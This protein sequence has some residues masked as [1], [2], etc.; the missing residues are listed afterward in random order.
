MDSPTNP[1]F[2]GLPTVLLIRNGPIVHK[3]YINRV[4]TQWPKLYIF[5]NGLKDKIFKECSLLSKTKEKQKN[6]S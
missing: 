2:G 3:Y 5:P 1:V 4:S 6:S